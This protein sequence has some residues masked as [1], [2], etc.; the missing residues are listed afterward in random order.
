MLFD[1]PRGVSHV[2][3]SRLDQVPDAVELA[4]RLSNF[5]VNRLH[6]VAVL[7]GSAIHLFVKRSH[8]AVNV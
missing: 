3:I 2:K 6:P 4:V 7:S 8:K 1:A 5:L